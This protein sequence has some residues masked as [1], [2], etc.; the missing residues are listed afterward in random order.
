M[1]KFCK[2][3]EFGDGVEIINDIKSKDVRVGTTLNVLGLAVWMIAGKEHKPKLQFCLT[4]KDYYDIDQ[5]NI[6][7]KYCPKCGR[8]L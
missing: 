3:D 8:K 6:P 4:D 5:I 1:C 7:I 2:P